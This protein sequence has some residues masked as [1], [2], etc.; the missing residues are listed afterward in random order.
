VL[1]FLQELEESYKY[2]IKILTLSKFGTFETVLP[3]QL[4]QCS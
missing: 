3:Q 1:K 4:E 2:N